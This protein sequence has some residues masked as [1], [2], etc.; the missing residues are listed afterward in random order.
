LGNDSALALSTTAVGVGTA[1]P[2]TKFTVFQSG[3][4]GIALADISGG[5]TGAAALQLSAGKA[6]GTTSF[7]IVQNAAGAFINQ[8]DNNPLAFFVNGAE[9]ATITSA[10][11]VGIGTSSPSGKLNVYSTEDVQYD[12][13]TFAA[14]LTISRVN[15]SGNNQ[16]AG[17][18]FI[19]TGDSGVT[20][21]AA[22]ISA[23]QKSLLSSADLVFQ[24]R[25]N[26]TRGERMRILAAGGL[27]FNGD[28]AAANALDDYEEGTWT[29]GI[30]FGGSSTG[31]TYSS[32]TGTYTKIGRQV[33]VNGY[34][35]ISNV[36]SST[37]VANLTGLP[38]AQA[39]GTGNYSSASAYLV[40]ISFANQFMLI[41]LGGTALT[42]YE[43]TEAGSVTALT[44]ADFANDSEVLI[45][46]TYF[47]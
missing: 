14:D 35:F 37:G 41:G 5:S 33:T 26:G 43:N 1:T 17:L 29:M 21:G 13:T 3:T 22:A 38:F 25:S 10:G 34:L 45:S 9:R 47:V 19:A 40:N 30:Q 4:S 16:V 8:R 31:A 28:T 7:D 23:E 11:N 2:N 24:T 36:G 12:A 6:L 15:A 46:F 18:T 39:G 44:N 42:F 27:T 20:T 32:N